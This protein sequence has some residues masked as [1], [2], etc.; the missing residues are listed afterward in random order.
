TSASAP[1]GTDTLTLD[2]RG[3]LL[4]TTGPSG[5]S[6]FAYN[7]DGLTT[8]R[9]DASGTSSY[10]YDTDD[11]LH[12]ITDASTGTVL[13]LSY[14]ALSQPSG[15]TYGAGADTR[16]F[17]YDHLHRLT[18]DTLKTNGGSTIASITYGY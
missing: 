13:T 7:G 6:S 5:A 9:T 11:R 18:S 16:S 14:N 15:I 17:G 10:T 1:G 3:L 12:T 8:S 4:S 2:D